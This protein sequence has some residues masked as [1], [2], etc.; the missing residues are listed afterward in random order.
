MSFAAYATTGEALYILVDDAPQ[1]IQGPNN[2]RELAVILIFEWG[3]IACPHLLYVS[4]LFDDCI[5]HFSL[6][7]LHSLCLR[8]L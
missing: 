8:C 4:A 2:E 3:I 7:I 5:I 1:E 6:S